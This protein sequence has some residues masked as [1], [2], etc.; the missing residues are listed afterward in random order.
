MRSK[1]R[2][3]V[4][5]TLLFA[6]PAWSEPKAESIVDEARAF[7][8]GYARDLASG[9]RDAIADRYDRSGAY[10]LVGGT[11][12]FSAYPKIVRDYQRDWQPPSSFEWRDLQF[13][14]SGPDGVVVNGTFLWGAPKG[15]ITFLY[16][17][18]LRYQDGKLRIRLEHETPVRAPTPNN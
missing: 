12:E 11:R 4:I 16:T 10:F 5:L 15:P 14:A 7:M 17:G 2:L 1:F 9:D 6:K 18:F 8:A 13:D 3:L